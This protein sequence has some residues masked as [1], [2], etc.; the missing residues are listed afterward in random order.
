MGLR[1]RPPGR[2]FSRAGL[3]PAEHRP[4]NSVP[5]L[6]RRHPAFDLVLDRARAFADRP[7][8]RPDDL[9][10]DLGDEGIPSGLEMGLVD[11]PVAKVLDRR[12]VVV[13]VG[14]TREDDQLGDL[15]QVAVDVEGPESKARDRRGVIDSRCGRGVAGHRA[16]SSADR[17][18]LNGLR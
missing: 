15:R 10:V 17:G 16:A 2:D 14:G 13:P 7:H 1:T 8:R 5:P 4:T 6:S 3:I 11:E 12:R 18:G 9:P